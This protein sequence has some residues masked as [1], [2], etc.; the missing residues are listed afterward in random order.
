MM[1]V[2]D[3][4]RAALVCLTGGA[5]DAISYLRFGTFVGAMTGSTVLLG[6]DIASYRIDQ[7]IYHGGIIGVFFV[8]GMLTHFAQLHKVLATLPLLL[9]A[10][11]L[12]ASELVAGPWSA[13]LCAAALAVQNAGVRQVGGVSLNSVFITGDLLSLGAAISRG[14]CPRR[15]KETA[16]LA[17]GLV[18]YAAGALAG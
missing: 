14:K 1:G 13:T 16:V 5:A 12:G 8:A 3:L 6:I 7:A 15:R 10:V 4:G 17:T 2:W 18:S 11:L 9:A